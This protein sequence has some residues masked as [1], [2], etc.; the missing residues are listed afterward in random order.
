MDIRYLKTFSAIISSVASFCMP[1][2]SNILNNTS[3]FWL[4]ILASDAFTYLN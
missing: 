4:E 3:L 2:R 1:E